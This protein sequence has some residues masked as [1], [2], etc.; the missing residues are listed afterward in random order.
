M[1]RSVRSRRVSP[2]ASS[3]WRGGGPPAPAGQMGIMVS[4]LLELHWQEGE[5]FLG[6][7]S[8]L[9]KVFMTSGGTIGSSHSDMLLLQVILEEHE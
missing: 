8:R 5:G 2:V 1:F 9:W 7:H 4:F 6:D 3:R